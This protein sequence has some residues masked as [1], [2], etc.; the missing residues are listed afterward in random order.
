[1]KHLYLVRHGETVFNKEG[2][3]QGGGLDSPLTEIGREQAQGLANY[4]EKSEVTFDYFYCSPQGRAMETAE[5]INRVIKKEIYTD[6]LIK[7]IYCGEMEGKLHSEIEK[8]K[9]ERLRLD[10]LE[11]YTGGE[12]LNDVRKRAKL[13]LDKIQKEGDTSAL[14]VSHGN[15]IRAVTS[16][17]VGMPAEFGMRIFLD[18]TGFSYLAKFSDLYRIALW[19]QVSHCLDFPK[20]FV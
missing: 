3:I 13:F 15:F 6:E 18:N 10:P 5:I 8:S 12:S 19:G 11:A 20:K 16:V 4:F 2:R 9:L 17:A 7:E 14:I 1:M